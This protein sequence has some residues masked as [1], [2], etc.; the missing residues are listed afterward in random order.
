MGR[1][2]DE[3]AR[4]SGPDGLVGSVTSRQFRLVAAR[5]TPEYVY[6]PMG[7]TTR[8]PR[9]R[10]GAVGPARAARAGP[11][12]AA[13]PARDASQCAFAP[14]RRAAQ[15]DVS[16]GKTGRAVVENLKS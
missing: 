5:D 7:H 13:D 2:P 8:R 11:G 12:R 9:T 1:E 4:Q 14:A 15:V 3:V 16:Y 10:A 6:G